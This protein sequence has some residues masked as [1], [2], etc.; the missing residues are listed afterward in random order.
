MVLNYVKLSDESLGACQAGEVS[1]VSSAVVY[2]NGSSYQWFHE[3]I[4]RHNVT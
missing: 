4:S 3:N 2:L 1:M